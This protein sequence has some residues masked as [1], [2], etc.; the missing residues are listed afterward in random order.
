MCEY[1]LGETAQGTPLTAITRHM[2]GLLAGQPGAKALRQVLSEEPRHG[3]ETTEV[4]GH[5]MA[6][7]ASGA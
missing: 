1:A 5:A 6:L 2:L 4:F 3:I 7:V